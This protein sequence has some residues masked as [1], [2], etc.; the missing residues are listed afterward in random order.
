MRNP[1]MNS[2]YKDSMFRM[3][4]NEKEELLSFYNAVNGTDYTDASELEI[5]TLEDVVYMSMKNDVS[6]IIDGRLSLY[7]HQS[8]WNGNMPLRNLLYISILLS[9]ITADK[10]LY[11]SK[12]IPLP[13]PQFITFYNGSV[14]KPDRMVQKLSQAY[15]VTADEVNLELTVVVLNINYGRN[16]ELM[17]KC[18][19][20]AEYAYYVEKVREYSKERTIEEAV[21]MAIEHCIKSNKLAEFLRTNR[22]EVVH[23]SIFEYDAEKHIAMEKED[24]WNEGIERGIECGIECGIERGKILLIKKKVER[25]KSMEIIADELEC[26]IEEIRELYEVVKRCGTTCTI[27][28]IMS[29]IAQN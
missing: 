7:E 22:N 13:N 3:L 5:N 20:L 1:I 9:G 15:E 12:T 17:K 4:F 25:E 14:N 29:L 6:F 26:D 23:M 18:P 24:S 21:E 27:E 8:T 19:T 2:K 16:K 10:N 28:E 11:G